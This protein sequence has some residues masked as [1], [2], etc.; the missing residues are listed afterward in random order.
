M[1]YIE[2][3][4]PE[5]ITSRSA[6]E[7]LKATKSESALALIVPTARRIP[8]A[9]EP[10]KNEI[11]KVDLFCKTP[12][13]VRFKKVQQPLVMLNLN[14]CEPLR[15]NRHLWIKNG[16]NGF[17]AQIFKTGEKVYRTDFIQL[18]RGSNKLLIE[19]VLKDGQKRVQSLEIISGS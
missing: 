12:E 5:K 15:S 1:S 19:T 2:P 7:I 3:S 14:I 17:R 8:A 18:S 4:V 9:V 13:K 16:T 10:N 6:E 11:L